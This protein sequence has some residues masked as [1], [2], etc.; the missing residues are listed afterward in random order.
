[1][2]FEYA[3]TFSL[4][5]IYTIV[6]HFWMDIKEL[7]IDSRRNHMMVGSVLTIGLIS[8]QA[9]I[10]IITGILTIILTFLL[11]YLEKRQGKVVFG[12]GDKEILAWSIPGISLV[13]GYYYAALFLALLMVSFFVLAFLKKTNNLVLQKLP[14][15]VF[16]SLAYLI[17]LVFGWFL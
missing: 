7:K 3:L 12:D 13:F 5:T 11:S 2:I 8:H 6:R 10:L 17:V 14:G 9:E 4:L 16:I 1:M 15:L